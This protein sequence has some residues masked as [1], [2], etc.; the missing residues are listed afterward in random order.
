MKPI[1]ELIEVIS[2]RAGLRN[3]REVGESMRTGRRSSDDG[4]EGI[5]LGDRVGELLEVVGSDLLDFGQLVI[6]GM[7]STTGDADPDTGALFGHGNS[8]FNRAGHTLQSANPNDTWD[9][10]GS[11]AYAGQNTRQQLRTEAI[12][13]AD[14][15]VHRV[16][17]REAFQITLRRGYLDDQSNFLAK[18]S[19]ATFPLQFIPR[20]GEAAKLA[21]EAAALQAAL[22]LSGHELYQLHTEVSANATDLQQ[23]VGRYAGVADG[24]ELPGAGVDFDPPAPPPG[25]DAPPSSVPVPPPVATGGSTGYGAP[26]AGGVGTAPDLGGT[27]VPPESPSATP[28]VVSEAAA[29][30]A[31][32]PSQMVAAAPGAAAAVLGSVLS[33]LAGLVAGAAIAAGQLA[34]ASTQNGGQERD[35]TTVD[36]E[37]EAPHKGEEDHED[38]K[39]NQEAGPDGAAETETG[40]VAGERSPIST[41]TDFEADR[42]QTAATV[43]LDPDIAPGSPTGSSPHDTK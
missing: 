1:G 23:A 29:V 27:P 41:E 4:P 15:E 20:Y 6:A 11:R 16:L 28:T 37:N 10:A 5:R 19:Y 32:A 35:D 39:D 22:S 25:V 26:A 14:R 24:A 21:I 40:D 13:D 7:K 33:P 3:V 30:P 31:S 43:R 34:A 42:P 36:H 17:F 9:G 2:E 18:T 8:G 12:A 38:Q